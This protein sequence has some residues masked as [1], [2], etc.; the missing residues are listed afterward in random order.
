MRKAHL[1]CTDL[2]YSIL[3]ERRFLS[4]YTP[5]GDCSN[6]SATALAYAGELRGTLTGCYHLGNGHRTYNPV[7]MRFHSGD[8]LSP[9]GKG[10]LNAYAYCLGDPINHRDPSGQ[11]VEDYLFP[12]LSVLSN[13]LGVFITG[14]R[15][16]AMFKMRALSS[17]SPTSVVADTSVVLPP[18]TRLEWGLSVVSGVAGLAGLGL[19]FGRIAEPGEEWQSWMLA[20]LTGVSLVTSGVE[21]WRMFGAKPWIP[22]KVDTLQLSQ[23][24]FREALPPGSESSRRGATASAFSIRQGSV[25]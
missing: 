16:R 19:G 24:P 12:V 5:Y 22:A 9:F 2:Q 23:F 14:M 15:M 18:P 13:A 4:G 17:S 8:R 25:Q 3:A 7:L 1:L 6:G 20:S 11:Q 10:G 21:A